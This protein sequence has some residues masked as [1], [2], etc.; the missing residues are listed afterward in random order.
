METLYKQHF[1]KNISAHAELLVY[2]WSVPGETEVIVEDIERI[3][4][5]QFEEDRHN[6]K[7]KDWRFPLESDWCEHRI[8]YCN[9][10]YALMNL[11][12]IP[13]FDVPE[14]LRDADEGKQWRDV[15]FDVNCKFQ[16][17][18]NFFTLNIFIKQAPGMKYSPGYNADMGDTGILTKTKLD[19]RDGL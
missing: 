12:N 8:K 16:Y 18:I 11:F 4:F 6:K 14:L 7:M 2:D 3:D 1:L 19:I 13:R 5:S 9:E 15:W 17:L 10:K